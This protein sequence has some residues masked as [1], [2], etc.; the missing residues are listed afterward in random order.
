MSYIVRGLL[1]GSEG[2]PHV[3]LTRSEL[4]RNGVNDGDTGK[5]SARCVQGNSLAGPSGISRAVQPN[6]I[7]KR[8]ARASRFLSKVHSKALEVSSTDPSNNIST[9]PQPES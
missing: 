7:S 8:A 5:N 3:I 9:A 4:L 1:S 2:Y 6:E